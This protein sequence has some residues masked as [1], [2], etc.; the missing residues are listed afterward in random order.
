MG[1]QSLG[2]SYALKG[3]RVRRGIFTTFRSL[4]FGSYSMLYIVYLPRLQGFGYVLLH[5]FGEQKDF[6][7]GMMRL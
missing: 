3:Y 7:G 2:D 1:N 5:K 4:I 6:K